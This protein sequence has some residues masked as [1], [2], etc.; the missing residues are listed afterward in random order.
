MAPVEEYPRG[1]RIHYPA[2]GKHFPLD[3]EVAVETFGELAA[4]VAQMHG[5]CERLQRVHELLS[6]FNELFSAL[7]YGL[8][9]NAWCV[10]FT[11]APTR[12]SFRQ[13]KQLHRL[14]ARIDEVERVLEH[15]RERGAKEEV[16]PVRSAASSRPLSA[17]KLPSSSSERL[18]RSTS[19]PETRLPRPN[20][21]QPPR[22]MRGVAGASSGP[23]NAGNADKTEGGTTAKRA[24]RGT[25]TPSRVGKK[26]VPIRERPPFR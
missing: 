8:S 4:G 25:R 15:Q 2:D 24:G 18:R 17:S 6:L 20:L 1:T 21:L 3:N 10:E 22:Y 14:Q 5:H 11:E 12:E 16:T 7:L 9:M 19:T 13:I 23:G 26:P